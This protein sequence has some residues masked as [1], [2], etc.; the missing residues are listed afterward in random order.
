MDILVNIGL[1]IT[2]LFY[3]C[4]KKKVVRKRSTYVFHAPDNTA[5]FDPVVCASLLV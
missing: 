4:K 3:F 1:F 5:A 2:T